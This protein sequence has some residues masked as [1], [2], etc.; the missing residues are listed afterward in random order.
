MKTGCWFHYVNDDR[1]KK[2]VIYK[3]HLHSIRVLRK[4]VITSTMFVKKFSS[5]VR[6][7]CRIH[8]MHPCRRLTPPQKEMRPR[9]DI[10]SS[11]G[12]API[13]ELWEMWKTASIPLLAG[14]LS[15]GVLV[16]VRVPPMGQLEL[17]DEELFDHLTVFKQMA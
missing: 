1:Q 14:S 5:L 3:F 2:I 12:E 4:I 16:P 9:F 8:R 11:D 17:C 15:S 10:R 7:R 13:L 6:W